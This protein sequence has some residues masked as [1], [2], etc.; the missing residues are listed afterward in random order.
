MIPEA[1]VFP[2]AL[3]I[4]EAL[5]PRGPR[6][7]RGPRVEGRRGREEQLLVIVLTNY[8]NH[9]RGSNSEPIQAMK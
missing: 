3:V 7:P 4:P 9:K 5:R 6:D 8:P 2:E 1:L